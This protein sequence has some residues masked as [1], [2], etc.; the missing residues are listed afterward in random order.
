MLMIVCI[1]SNVILAVFSIDYLRKMENNSVLMYQQRLLAMN[2]FTDF[3]LAI[4]QGDFDR[5]NE[6]HSSLGAYQFDSKMELYIKNLKSTLSQENIAE[7][8]AISEETQAYIVQRA[9]NQIEAYKEDISFGYFLLI[10]VSL[11]MI[12]VVVYFAVGGTRAVNIPTRELKKLLISAGQG[13]FTKSAT[14]DSKDE[15]GEVMRSY[16][17]MAAEVRELLK[18]VQKSASSVD[19]SNLRLQNASEKTTEAAIHISNDA[20]DLTRSTERSA[21]QLMMNTAA[22]QEIFTGIEY[23]AEK[24]QLID[25]SMKKTENEA[26]EGVQFVLEHK[27]K[28][29]EIELAVKKTNDKMLD[30]ANNT[31]EIGQVIQIINSIA[32]QTTLLALNAA[33]EAARAGEYGKGFSVVASEVRK[34]ADQS[35]QSTKV[36]ENIIQQI[37]NDS[38]MS[39]E[40]MV[41]AIQSVHV[42]FETT[43]QSATRFEQIVSSVNGIGPQIEE[44]STTI[45]QIKQN[46]KDVAD[47]STELSH[48]FDHN[49]DRIKQVSSSTVEQLSSTQEMHEEIQ[50]ITRNIQS[51]SHAIRRFTV[52]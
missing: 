28:M 14:Y 35:V 37:Q 50:K 6:I 1:I 20:T 48:L 44:V 23:I 29:N 34:L 11:I 24:V 5:A 3:D 39:I 32:E 36:I 2:A 15:L 21:E 9:K 30:L 46:T 10:A 42:G 4:D 26:N 12:A 17:Q 19:D 47:N 40:Y 22:I 33:I 52:K 51:L 8:L 49:A 27:E 38:T 41:Q 18:T 7:T 16:N 25:K 13:N 45:N 31:K 43:I